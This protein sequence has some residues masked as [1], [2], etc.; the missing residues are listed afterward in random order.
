MTELP[1]SPWVAGLVDAFSD[2]RNLYLTLELG[3]CGSFSNYLA[4]RALS[5][6]DCRFYF[7]NIV[8][9]INFIHSYGIVHRDIKP[10]NILM[11]G[12]GYLMLTDFGNSQMLTSQA[13]WYEAGTLNYVSPDCLGTSCPASIAT[14]LDWWSAG[15]IL[16]EMA[17]GRPV[18]VLVLVQME[19]E[20]TIQIGF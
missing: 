6:E 8:C 5:T 15:C 16:F 4:H 12:D 17:S 14:S 9:A 20:L 11:C 1:W 10:E 19:P 13:R 2:R 3:E 7:A 18:W